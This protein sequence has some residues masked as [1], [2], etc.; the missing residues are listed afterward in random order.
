MSNRSQTI[1]SFLYKGFQ[2]GLSF[3]ASV[4]AA[5]YLTE[6]DRGYFQAANVNVTTGMTFVGGYTNYYAFAIAKRPEDRVE[7]V[8]M[9]NLLIFSLSVLFWI[10]TLCLIF[11]RNPWFHIGG[12]WIW[13]LVCMPTTF[14]FGYGSRILNAIHEI[15]W[16]NRVNTAQPLLFVAIYLPFALFGKFPEQQRLLWTYSIWLSSYIL[17]VVV[18]MGVAYRLLGRKGVT[19][20][21]FSKLDWQGTLD[22]GSWS[23]VGNL[24]SYVNYRIDFWMVWAALPKQLSVYGVAV[25]S[26]EVLNTLA[27]SISSVVFARMTGGSEEDA[28][29]ITEIAT[30]QTLISSAIAAIGLYI[31]A[32]LLV[33][34]YGKRYGGLLDPFFILLPGLV[35]KGASNVII[36]YATNSLGRPKTAIWMN[37]VAILANFVSCVIFIPIIGMNGGALASTIS[38]FVGFVV[39]I[40]WFGRVTNRSPHGL[41]RIRMADFKPYVQLIRSAI[42]RLSNG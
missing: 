24:V 21:R 35:I 42:R 27:T 29:H 12:L 22:Y 25:A 23:S 32:P 18:T 28:I 4:L 6:T 9:G 1:T 36:Q 37:G 17:Q 13:V 2:S 7:I 15:P 8:Q 5:R 3:L 11:I 16:L 41:W 38:Y 40:V 39:Y 19:K 10:V 33:I 20:W 30:R 14:I 26:A 34:S 31:V